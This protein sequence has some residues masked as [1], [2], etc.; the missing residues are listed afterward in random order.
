VTTREF[1]SRLEGVKKCAKGWSARCPAHDDTK[2]SLTVTEGADKI[3]VYCHKGCP[4]EVICAALQIQTRDLFYDQRSEPAM[5]PKKIVCTYRY[6]DEDGVVLYEKVRYQPKSFAIRRPS[7]EGF[8][9]SLGEETRRLL[10]NLP[11]LQGREEIAWVAGEKDADRLTN[12]GLPATTNVEGEGADLKDYMFTQL[13]DAGVKRVLLFSD[14]DVTG[15]ARAVALQR[16]L[17]TEHFCVKPIVLFHGPVPDARGQDVS[18]YLSQ[19][20]MK[21]LL[22]QI[23]ATPWISS[24][25]TTKSAEPTRFSIVTPAESFITKYVTLAQRRTDAPP[26]GHELTA[27]LVLSALAGPR[28]R[29][30]LAHTAHGVRLVLWGMNL[31]DSTEGRKTVTNEMGVDIVREVLGPEAEAPWESSPQAFIQ[32]LARRSGQACVLARDE[33]VGLLLQMHRGGHMAGMSQVFIRAFD[34]FAIENARTKKRGK[35]GEAVNDSDRC[36]DPYLVQMGAA[37]RTAFL[38][39]A[40]ID[41]VLDGFL[42]RFIITTG[43]ASPRRQARISEAI[44]RARL[45]LI[46]HAGGFADHALDLSWALEER[47]RAE[48][49]QTF[50]PEAAGSSLKRLADA[51]LRVAALLAIDRTPSDDESVTI[52]A[53]DF[54]VAA[55]MGERWKRTTVEVLEALGRS[56][57]QADCETVLA[58]VRAHPNGLQIS[59][60]YRAHRNLKERDLI[61]VLSAL[62]TQELIRQ[63]ATED[64][65]RG[66]PPVVIYPVEPPG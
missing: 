46:A 13:R 30:P 59:T 33:Y 7:E 26:E 38:T 49:K 57:F 40:T 43:T 58:T 35:G 32:R 10:Y 31:V 65:R 15:Q 24:E 22:E 34:G 44:L 16:R 23:E 18:D 11:R 25:P 36:P 1:L 63:V 62:T 61:D 42:P 66:R 51:V 48:A 21:A 17:V 19:H 5:E 28:P 2:P 8:I 6:L 60:L 27:N 29:I 3:L 56:R 41:D 12:L 37:T 9:W 55:Q 54:H 20:P 39:H 47:H 53:D 4:V 64:G 14:Y 52:E 50:R 45:A